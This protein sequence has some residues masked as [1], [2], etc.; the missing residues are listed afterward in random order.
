MFAFSIPIR[1][2]N[3]IATFIQVLNFRTNNNCVGQV[4]PCCDCLKRV[5]LFMSGMHIQNFTC[6]SYCNYHDVRFV[7]FLFQPKSSNTFLPSL[8][9]L[10]IRSWLLWRHVECGCV[11]GLVAISYFLLLHRLPHSDPGW[12]WRIYGSELKMDKGWI[13]LIWWPDSTDWFC[14]RQPSMDGGPYATNGNNKD[15]AKKYP[16]KIPQG[17]WAGQ[18]RSLNSFL[19]I[20]CQFTFPCSPTWSWNSFYYH[21]TSVRPRSH[22]LIGIFGDKCVVVG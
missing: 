18:K 19:S 2:Y 16:K 4:Y 21:L 22:P 11:D 6:G 12:G 10:E 3:I 8:E 1:V 9:I 14:Q 13:N 7:I 5:I 20:L 15:W 17:C